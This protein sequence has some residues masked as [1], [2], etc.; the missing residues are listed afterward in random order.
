MDNLCIQTERLLLRLATHEDA[1]VY[2]R[3]FELNR[4]HLT[5]WFPTFDEERTTTVFWEK[6]IATYA[7]EAAQDRAYRFGVFEKDSTV[8]V[9]CVNFSQV[10]RGPFQACYVGYHFGKS[11]EGK[12]LMTEAVSATVQYAFDTLKLHRV[13]ANYMPENVRSAKLLDK[14]GFEIEGLAKQY[15]WINGAWR[16]H[17]LT[18]LTAK[19]SPSEVACA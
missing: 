16:D 4:D 18:A 14:I 6:Q 7:E 19:T 1:G 15:L 3:F 17:V 9:G 12:G 5:P 2:A 8:L 11:H 13:M 10:F